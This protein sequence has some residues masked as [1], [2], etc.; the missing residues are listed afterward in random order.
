MLTLDGEWGGG[1]CDFYGRGY[2]HWE[3]THG[4][5]TRWEPMQPGA[6]FQCGDSVIAHF[7]LPET[8]RSHSS[9]KATYGV[10]MN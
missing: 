2:T 3:G 9:P 8:L 5:G 7:V 6:I 1:S 4:E 10:L